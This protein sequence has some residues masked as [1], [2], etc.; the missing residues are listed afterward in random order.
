MDRRN[1][2]RA[3]WVAAV[4][5]LGATV[6][7][8]TGRATPMSYTLIAQGAS[9]ALNGSAFSNQTI[10]LTGIGDTNNAVVVNGWPAVP[11]A[12]TYQI[13][14]TIATPSEPFYFVDARQIG[15]ASY[16]FGFT[17]EDAARG[18]GFKLPVPDNW[19]WDT[20]IS[21]Q[22]AVTNGHGAFQ[23][24]QGALDVTTWNDAQFAAVATPEPSA[25]ALAVLGMM[26][27]LLRFRKA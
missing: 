5:L 20:P 6:A 25:L 18:N 11:V 19:I 1:Y 4:V 24:D 13:G 16:P 23:T 8:K 2:L 26:G 27:V 14:S 9:G 22:N 15:A 3:G 10:T 12:M 21:V 17:S 7:P